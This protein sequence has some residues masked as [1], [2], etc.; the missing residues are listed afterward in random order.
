MVDGPNLY[1]YVNQNPW[2]KFDPEGLA[3]ELV[4]RNSEDYDKV[5]KLQS[6]GDKL[7]KGVKLVKGFDKD[8]NA[9]G[10]W[11]AAQHLDGLVGE[12]GHRYTEGKFAGTNGIWFFDNKEHA[13][14]VKQ[15][16]DAYT[17][18]AIGGEAGSTVLAAGSSGLAGMD[19]LSGSALRTRA[20]T[21]EQVEAA[22]KLTKAERP[23]T[24]Y[25]R[26]TNAPP[27]KTA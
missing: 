6:D 7:Y 27:A 20:A 25:D 17:W 9:N 14:A 12:D 15:S 21:Q 4:I 18:I 8:G 10:A 24:V 1:A 3:A 26:I 22:T 11:A 2:T 16:F 5:R 13:Q 19:G 23:Q